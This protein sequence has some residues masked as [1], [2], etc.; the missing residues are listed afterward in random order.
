MIHDG[1]TESCTFA[2]ITLF[3][4]LGDDE[5]I[6]ALEV[7]N[8][9]KSAINKYLKEEDYP[10][11]ITK[12]FSWDTDMTGSLWEFIENEGFSFNVWGK[13]PIT[14]VIYID[15]IMDFI[16]GEENWFFKEENYNPYTKQPSC[17][18]EVKLS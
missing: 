14:K 9:F 1:N 13:T 10:E 4:L 18:N 11:D 17:F 5:D 16:T 6:T 8:R 3:Y 15:S 7:A 12:M 2:N